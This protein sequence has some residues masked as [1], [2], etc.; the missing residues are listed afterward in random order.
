L[1]EVE[2]KKLEFF[3]AVNSARHLA[4]VEEPMVMRSSSKKVQS[5]FKKP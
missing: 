3:D 5:V 1:K 2:K 4:P